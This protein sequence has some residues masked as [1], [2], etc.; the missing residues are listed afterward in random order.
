MT[1]VVDF[2]KH[3]AKEKFEKTNS[4]RQFQKLNYPQ[5]SQFFKTQK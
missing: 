5:A 2:S 3:K 1:S 4:F